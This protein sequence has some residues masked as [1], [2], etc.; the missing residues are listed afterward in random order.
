MICVSHD[1]DFLDS[2]CTDIIHLDNQLLNY[3]RGGYSGFR[4]M[5]GQKKVETAR[6]FKKMQDELK[7]LKKGGLGKDKAEEQIKKKFNL[8]TVSEINEKPK[9]YIVNY[10]LNK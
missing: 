7:A 2:I 10:L 3:Y 8:N 1:A 4:K 5:L 6:E 9:D